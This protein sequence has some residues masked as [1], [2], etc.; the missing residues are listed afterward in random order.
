[1]TAEAHVCYFCDEPTET[2]VRDVVSGKK[3]PICEDCFQ[4]IYPSKKNK[5]LLH[6]WTILFPAVEE[7]RV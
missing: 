5:Q 7:E 1:M 6:W 4:M 3:V 2:F